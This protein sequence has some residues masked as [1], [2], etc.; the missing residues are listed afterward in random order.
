VKVVDLETWK[1]F[2][3]ELLVLQTLRGG[4]QAKGSYTS[5]LLFRGHADADWPLQTTLERSKP[6]R[7][8]LVDYYK[9]I[10]RMQSEIE[11]FTGIRWNILGW[12]K[13]NQWATTTDLVPGD[14][15]DYDCM[16]WLRHQGFPSP[17]LDWTRSPYIAAYFAFANPET[18]AKRVSIYAF[19]EYVTGHK[20]GSKTH[21]EIMGLGPY[22]RG[23]RRHFLQQSQ[24]TICV[25]HD[26]QWEYADHESVF[27]K[28]EENQDFLWK[29]TL[30]ASERPAV[31]KQLEMFNITAFSLFGSEESLL[32]T[33]ALR[34]FIIGKG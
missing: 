3:K 13:Y 29:F 14:F 10:T 12:E 30:P 25:V 31:L 9:V 20:V 5:P 26:G 2:E 34:E 16:L 28:G 7:T 21:P 19:L 8:V 23:H 18:T 22:I 4:H 6:G 11:T 15:P 33:M 24:Y 17:L 32:R 27:A 1:D